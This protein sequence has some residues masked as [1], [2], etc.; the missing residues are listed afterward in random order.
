MDRDPILGDFPRWRSR[1]N[2]YCTPH[3]VCVPQECF[4]ADFEVFSHFFGIVA[5]PL[6]VV[7]CPRVPVCCSRAPLGCGN[8]TSYLCVLCGMLLRPLRQGAVAWCCESEDLDRFLVSHH[9]VSRL[10]CARVSLWDVPRTGPLV[11]TLY[12]SSCDRVIVVPGGR[13]C[14]CAAGVVRVVF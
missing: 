3:R 6:L 13:S 2:S 1:Y 4:D 8:D 14:V 9:A 5:R 7:L 10:F 12:P 11:E